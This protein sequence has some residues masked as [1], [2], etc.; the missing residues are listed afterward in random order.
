[1]VG[2]ELAG[3]K[4]RVAGALTSSPVDLTTAFDRRLEQYERH[5]EEMERPED[6]NAGFVKALLEMRKNR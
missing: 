1:M 6:R 5:T 3:K 2:H 4:R